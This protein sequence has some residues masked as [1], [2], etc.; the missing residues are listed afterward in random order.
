MWINKE[1][2][3]PPVIVT[4]NGVSDKGGLDDRDRINYF[5]SYLEKVLDAIVSDLL[6]SSLLNFI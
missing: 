1:Y 6:Y 4:E 3:N 5:N 2:D